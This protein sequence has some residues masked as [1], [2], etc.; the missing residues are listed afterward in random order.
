MH[1][2]PL[3]TKTYHSDERQRQVVELT[4]RGQR[5]WD[6]ELRPALGTSPKQHACGRVALGWAPCKVLDTDW[7]CGTSFFFLREE[8]EAS[9]EVCEHF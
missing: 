7:L 9:R 1:E 5:S 6:G 8:V 3:Q 2:L 4:K